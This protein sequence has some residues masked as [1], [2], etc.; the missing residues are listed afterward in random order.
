MPVYNAEKFLAEA[1]ESI[2]NQTFTDFEFL[3]FNDGSTDN[4]LKIIQQYQRKDSRIKL[5]YSGENKGY[6]FHLNEGIRLAKGKYIAR[7]DAD[8]IALPERFAKQVDFLERN[9]EYV[10]CG[11]RAETFGTT[12][13]TIALPLSNEDIKLK[14]LCITPFVHPSVMLRKSTLWENNL[15]YDEKAMP[16]EDRKLWLQLAP[17]GKMH[18]LEESLLLYRVHGQNISLQKRA[19]TQIAYLTKYEKKYISYFFSKCN[20]SDEDIHL[21]HLMLYRRETMNIEQIKKL[22]EV[23]SKIENQSIVVENIDDKDIKKFLREKLF[24]LCTTSTHLGVP[25]WHLYNNSKMIPASVS[26]FLRAKFF[27]KCLVRYTPQEV[28]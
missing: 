18:N 11:S 24:Y 7:M 4:S 15:F 6:V 3:I 23:I 14:M 25:L 21:L 16:A 22:I 10:I 19:S 13:S 5:V 20:L 8:D 12:Q 26:F 28:L 27:L 9:P 2:L 1:I 17:L